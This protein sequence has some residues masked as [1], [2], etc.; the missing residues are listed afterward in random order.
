MG[1]SWIHFRMDP[2]AC[3]IQFPKGGLRPPLGI[4]FSFDIFIE[5]FVARARPDRSLCGSNL[6]L[7]LH[8]H[9]AC[10]TECLPT[11]TIQARLGS[12]PTSQANM[13]WR[14]KVRSG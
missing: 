10:Q 5:T 12:F 13:Y 1:F 9:A 7:L 6:G 11:A 14:M 2:P 8:T 3:G 4:V